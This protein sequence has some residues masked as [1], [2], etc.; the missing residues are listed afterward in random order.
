MPVTIRDAED[1]YLLGSTDFARFLKEF[2]G[3]F[4]A[5]VGI[6]LLGMTLAAL[7]QDPAKAANI[8]PEA[9]A[10]V[11]GLF[12]SLTKNTAPT[13]QQPSAARWKG[14]GADYGPPTLPPPPTG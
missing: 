8:P 14:K 4:W 11:Q 7:K 6:A 10:K 12:A 3:Q 2:Q 1:A 13:E 5:P 9:L